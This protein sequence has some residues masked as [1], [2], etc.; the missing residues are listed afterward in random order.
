MGQNHC[1]SNSRGVVGTISK[2]E[3]R[4]RERAEHVYFM[5][6]P[7]SLFKLGIYLGKLNKHHVTKLLLG[8]N[9]IELLVIAGNAV[10][11]TKVDIKAFIHI[12]S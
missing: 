11:T 4:G 1:P 7:T 2:G 12:Y 6:E 5:Y 3:G 10:N 9:G 8:R